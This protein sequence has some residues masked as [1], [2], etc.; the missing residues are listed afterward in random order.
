MRQLKF[1]SIFIIIIILLEFAMPLATVYAANEIDIVFNDSNLYNAIVE[2]LGGKISSKDDT[3]KSIRI[4]DNN[5][6]TVQSLDLHSKEISDIHGIEKFTSLSTLQIYSNKIEDISALQNNTSIRILNF[7]DNKLSEEDLT[8]FS[9]MTNLTTL[10]I[11]KNSN[12]TDISKLYT[13]QNLEEL[14]ASDN[15]ITDIS[16]ISGLSKLKRLGLSSNKIQN[17]TAVYSLNNLEELNLANNKIKDI[18]GL[19]N[20]KNLV[21][22]NL[23]RNSI[24]NMPT[25]D[26]MQSENL[27]IGNQVFNTTIIQ[28]TEQEVEIQLP[29]IFK[30][31]TNSQSLYYST[32]GLEVENCKLNSDGNI[33]AN[34]NTVA[35]LNGKVLI[36]SGILKGTYFFMYGVGVKYQINLTTDEYLKSIDLDLNSDEQV[37]LDDAE[38][39]KKYYSKE[40]LTDE[41]NQKVIS[42]D[43][44]NDDKINQKDYNRFVKYI[45]GESNILFTSEFDTTGK[46]NNDI[47]AE[48]TTEDPDLDI[49]EMY[50]F[51]QNGEHE[52]TFLDENGKQQTIIAVVNCIDKEEL[53]YKM[54]YSTTTLTN[55]EVTVTIKAN[56]QLENIYDS[57]TDDN[58]N[59]IDT[60]WTLLED[61][62]T[63]TKTYTENATDIASIMDLAG[64]CINIT[65]EINN[66]TSDE[67]PAAKLLMKKENISGEN[68]TNDTWTNKNVYIEIDEES[69]T[70]GTTVTYSINGQGSYTGSNILSQ[71]G[72]YTVE[73]KVTD[74][75]DRIA[76]TTYTIKIDK[77]MPEVG[78]LVIKEESSLGE[79]LENGI[80]TNKNVYVSVSKGQDN[81]SGHKVTKYILNG[82]VETSDPQIVR[83]TNTYNIIVITEDNAGN[84]SQKDYSFQIDKETPILSVKYQQNDNNTITVTITSNKQIQNSDGWTLSQ[85]KYSMTKTYSI[86]KTETITVKDL[87]GNES[88][89]VVEV[90][91]LSIKTFIIDV[92]YSTKELTNKN[93]LVT[94]TSTKP[95]QQ[96]SGWIL[97]SNSC[98]QTKEYS[99]NTTQTLTVQDLDNNS[100]PAHINIANIDKQAPMVNIRYSI[101][102]QTNLDVTVTL[103]SN[104]EIQ[105]ISGWILSTDKL[106]LTKVYSNNTQENVIIKDLAGNQVSVD[107]NVQNIDKTTPICT[108]T[109]NPTEETYDPV[110]VTITS[111]K[112]VQEVTGW[113]RSSDKKSLSKTFV[114]NTTETVIVKDVLN[115][116][117]KVEV[118]VEN[119][120]Q[121][122][123]INTDVYDV[124]KDGYITKIQPNT[125]MQQFMKNLGL[126]M[127]S[128]Y[129]GIIKTGMTF[130]VNDTTYTLIVAGDITKD[131]IEDVQDLSN[132]ILHLSN[133]EGKLLTGVALKAADVN[134]D[135]EVDIRDLSK[136]CLTITNQ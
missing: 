20:K 91:S 132:L 58:G 39:I 90:S 121:K 119:I 116:Q 120:M 41:E 93:V 123:D 69:K 43:V 97:S 124:S 134:C 4:T 106:S 129:T 81:L 79:V 45:N 13:L 14:N 47:I 83:N 55:G 10:G 128:S 21:K 31:A 125:T 38:V 76:I 98:A 114:K 105:P 17:I 131:G 94:I 80:V 133:M 71:E 112:E 50:V 37:N 11:A 92:D 35:K 32:D 26:W 25:I 36:K 23:Q 85:D 60:G 65:V 64:N 77:T 8:V 18:T 62:Y 100:L 42:M 126:S 89:V 109:Y 87:L 2:T 15:E 108:V 88:T 102:T 5:I 16:G 33:L 46:T 56:K 63:I 61:G 104:E 49:D 9:T 48:L 3:Q 72:T 67:I 115:N 22:L 40:T 12:I 28:S 86:N 7:N 27:F 135:K 78:N 117:T 99:A 57:F 68:Y 30:Q 101:Q 96:L 113:R 19:E 6:S 107:V 52:F 73:V 95:M 44:N 118:K 103:I 74:N 122:Q 59:K 130:K 54:S 66:I 34:P 75:T 1:L 53:T 29:E 82:N 70:E 51:T 84:K 127:E 111:N 24:S 136:M 110:T